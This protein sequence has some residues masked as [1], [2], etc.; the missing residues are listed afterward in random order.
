M[1]KL[2]SVILAAA[3]LL[4]AITA[5]PAFAAEENSEIDLSDGKT[6]SVKMTGKT[7]FKYTAEKDCWLWVKV[8]EASDDPYLHI[9]EGSEKYYNNPFENG[10]LVVM[11]KGQTC[12][13]IPNIS[14]TEEIDASVQAVEASPQE[15]KNGGV[16]GSCP[17]GGISVYSYTPE[18]DGILDISFKTD[19][20]SEVRC[21]FYTLDEEYME[22]IVMAQ[23]ED[24]S[25]TKQISQKA[26][27]G[28]TYYLL[29]VNDNENNIGTEVDVDFAAYPEIT[30]NNQT[31]AVIGGKET[32]F[33]YKSDHDGFVGIVLS[34]ESA[35]T[36]YG[37]YLLVRQYSSSF[38]SINSYYGGRYSHS[39]S[40]PFN[41]TVESGETYYFSIAI[42]DAPDDVQK[43]IEFT[44]N[45]YP[46][47]ELKF[48]EPVEVK[49]EDSGYSKFY[50]FIA[51]KDM[52]AQFSIEGDTRSRFELRCVDN[53]SVP[54]SSV[55]YNSSVSY[56]CDL[57]EGKTYY[58][59][60]GFSD[61]STGSYILTA[62]EKVPD[63]IKL[64][65]TKEVAVKSSSSENYFI[66]VPEEDMVIELYSD[67]DNGDV[68]G[69]ILDSDKNEI[70]TPSGRISNSLPV[71]APVKAGETYYLKTSTW[72]SIDS[73]TV[74]VREFET[75]EIAMDEVK[76]VIFDENNKVKWFKF[77]APYDTYAAVKSDLDKKAENENDD[78]VDYD[79]DDDESVLKYNYYSG[80]K[81]T[82][83]TFFG[84]AEKGDTYYIKV[85]YS[86]SSNP[87]ATANI[88]VF[89]DCGTI[90]TGET[91]KLKYGEYLKYTADKD[92]VIMYSSEGIADDEYLQFHIVQAHR[93]WIG[94]ITH[95]GGIASQG[96]FHRSF[97][98]EEGETYFMEVDHKTENDVMLTWAEL[99]EDSIKLNTEYE[100]NNYAY[101]KF[102]PD[103]D[104]SVSFESVNSE[105]NVFGTVYDGI[106]YVLKTNGFT[107]IEGAH[108]D[109]G[110]G[111]D[112]AVHYDLEEGVTYYLG[113]ETQDGTSGKFRVIL[114][115]DE[116]SRPTE[117]VTQPTEPVTQ[118]TEPVTQPT[119]PVEEIIAGDVNG[120]GKIN[121]ADAT[122]IQKHVAEL[123]TLN[124]RQ[125]KAADVN[126]DG[127]VN[128]ADATAIQK[129]V[130]EL[131]D[132]F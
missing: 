8:L 75:E 99:P 29:C 31:S 126:H 35:Q 78:D 129:Y 68:N 32:Y 59:T 95:V 82:Y 48:N 70:S 98:V 69:G 102:V 101:F 97:A 61:Q 96:N 104:M 2:L 94:D 91:K 50:K 87:E 9:P 6:V 18:E 118:P 5:V 119:E 36:D 90:K 80:D 24:P 125:L 10:R 76:S 132:H 17:G 65:E 85:K 103:R 62:A 45:K 46:L 43:N 89:E 38:R 51:E 112:F 113:A 54:V 106:M 100:I 77:T 114:K 131:I 63:P 120:D 57:K 11:N 44:L 81:F 25:A 115:A 52:L 26:T 122:A 21:G 84:L 19:D 124:E 53:N 123:I 39:L 79:D 128:I 110:D 73:Y 117:P 4:T 130:A 34:E 33:R 49:I 14:P 83:G 127:K 55:S 1:K 71:I 47:E 41:F 22:S 40:A 67:Y 7:V 56:T 58:I 121:I 3:L 42:D 20:E 64:N 15:I 74:G 37:D 111:N 28:T 23:Y 72:R 108:E 60:A 16:T 109:K 105:A 92:A 66:F 116:G 93:N 88:T 12:K 13:L 107:K 30:S 27:A 86:D